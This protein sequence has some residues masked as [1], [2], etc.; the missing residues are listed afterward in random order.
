MRYQGKITNWK[1]EQGFGFVTP[2]GGGKDVFLHVKSFSRSK[3]RP[4]GNELVS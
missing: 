1:D 2:N 3:K 4:V